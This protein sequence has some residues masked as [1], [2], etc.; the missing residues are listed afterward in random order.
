MESSDPVNLLAPCGKLRRGSCHAPHQECAAKKVFRKAVFG[1]ASHAVDLKKG[2]SMLPD[3]VS[4]EEIWHRSKVGCFSGGASEAK[5]TRTQL[6][7]HLNADNQT[8]S[9]HTLAKN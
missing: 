7:N 8:T 6:Y 4:D 9:L 2:S 5:S 1:I 3:P